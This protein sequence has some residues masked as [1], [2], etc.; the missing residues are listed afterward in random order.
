MLTIQIAIGRGGRLI[1]R[2]TPGTPY[3]GR[4]SAG[5]GRLDAVAAGA[6]KFGA[7]KFAAAALG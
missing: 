7:G 5:T 3:T 4:A 6:A 2:W 1:A